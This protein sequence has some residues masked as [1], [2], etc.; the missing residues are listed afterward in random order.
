[1]GVLTGYQMSKIKIWEVEALWKVAIGEM[2]R[3]RKR[4]PG[5]YLAKRRV[6]IAFKVCMS[7]WK[8]GESR[9]SLLEWDEA[10]WTEANL[11]LYEYQQAYWK[12]YRLHSQ[13]RLQHT[14]ES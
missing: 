2:D 14:F 7:A 12:A 11:T 5:W 3:W 8:T 4:G 9:E 13:G 10:A 1:M 6:D